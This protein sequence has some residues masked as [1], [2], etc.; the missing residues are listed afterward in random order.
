MSEFRT[1]KAYP[2]IEVSKEGKFR[3]R[4][5][6]AYKG[7][8]IVMTE[9]REI[10]VTKMYNNLTVVFPKFNKDMRLVFSE[11]DAIKHFVDTWIGFGIP[12]R[13][14]SFINGDAQDLSL[15]NIRIR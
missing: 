6:K 14:I 10:P 15:N 13:K 7:K 9:T 8:E 11:E 2:T 12:K 5:V 1:I 3:H 4:A